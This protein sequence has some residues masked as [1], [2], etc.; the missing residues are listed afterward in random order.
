MGERHGGITLIRKIVKLMNVGLFRDATISGAIDFGKVTLIYGENGRGKSTLSAIM[1]AC[2]Q[3]DSGRI[4]ARKTI[5]SQAAPEIA[6]L[7]QSGNQSST[8]R[9]DNGNWSGYVPS[10]LIFD[11]EF[12]DQNVYSGFVVSP[13]QRQSLL[14]F[15]LGDQIV[16]LKQ[17]VD[18]LT[19]KIDQQTTLK[20][21]AERTLTAFASPYSVAN[22]IKLQPVQ[23]IRQQIATTQKRIEATKNAQNLLAR[24]YPTRFPPVSID[25]QRIL[26]VL[27][28]QLPNIERSA[29]EMVHSHI[30]KYNQTGLED[31][32]SQGQ[33]YTGLG[34]CPFCDRPLAGV[35]LI[36]MYRSFFNQA[37][38]DLGRCEIR[39]K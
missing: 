37:Y 31:W 14:D 23:D 6:I 2:A 28:K 3:A 24:K 13:G 10:I 1:R 25:I 17:K 9:F 33:L 39:T 35:N 19:Q 15:A 32:I 8:S 20:S 30:K 38:I 34:Q 22:Y 36:R 26:E 21:Q 18:E 27:Q 12:V 5:D 16:P 29:E 7:I 4:L 11:S